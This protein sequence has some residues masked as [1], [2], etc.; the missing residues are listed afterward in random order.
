[1]R[2]MIW[3]DHITDT[4]I[5]TPLQREPPTARCSFLGEADTPDEP[6]EIPDSHKPRGSRE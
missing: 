2:V 3:Q 6:H 4:F 1:M 5:L